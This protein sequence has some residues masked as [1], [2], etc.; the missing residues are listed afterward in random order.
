MYKYWKEMM[1][2][3]A[4][5]VKYERFNREDLCR[6]GDFAFTKVARVLDE[7]VDIAPLN[8]V[9]TISN[10]YVAGVSPDRHYAITMEF[11]PVFFKSE[12]PV[13]EATIF[14]E[15]HCSLYKLS[16]SADYDSGG[17]VTKINVD[18]DDAGVRGLQ[19]ELYVRYACIEAFICEK[20]EISLADFSKMFNIQSKSTVSRALRV[21]REVNPDAI[22]YNTSKRLYVPSSSYESKFLDESGSKFLRKL[23]DYLC[24]VNEYEIAAIKGINSKN[25]T[26]IDGVKNIVVS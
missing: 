20:G 3:E 14:L 9:V 12:D 6:L 19:V 4:L 2:L 7:Y 21:Y 8:Y 15:Q 17:F 22:V 26:L 18:K 24:L 16:L 1:L 23:D 5:L 10:S 25:R 13:K 11:E